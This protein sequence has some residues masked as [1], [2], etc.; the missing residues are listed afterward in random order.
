MENAGRPYLDLFQ[1]LLQ[2]V[3]IPRYYNDI[4]AF[5]SQLLG[6]AFAHALRGSGEEDRLL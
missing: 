6:Y 1:R 3:Y 4:R 2:L 5:G